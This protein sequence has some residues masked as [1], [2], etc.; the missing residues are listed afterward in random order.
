VTT[1][2]IY[3]GSFGVQSQ[4]IAPKKLKK[5]ARMFDIPVFYLAHT[6]KEITKNMHRLTEP[7]DIRGQ[8]SIAIESEFFYILHTF[9]QDDAF[10]NLVRVVKHRGYPGANGFFRL[11]WQDGA[12]WTD[13]R[14]NFKRVS[15]IFKKRDKI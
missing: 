15:E 3:D 2:K 4:T 11:N 1:S 10:V 14:L 7:E 5:I 13:D 9:T 8:A 12:Y 6:R